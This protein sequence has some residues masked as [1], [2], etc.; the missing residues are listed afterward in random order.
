MRF[1]L[2]NDDADQVVLLVESLV[3]II[4]I[5][6]TTSAGKGLKQTMKHK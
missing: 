5:E 1:E 3:L 4:S 2:A 6:T